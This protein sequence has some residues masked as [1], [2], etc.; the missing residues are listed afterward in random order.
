M[1][2]RTNPKFLNKTHGSPTV[3][4]LDAMLSMRGGC[5]GCGTRI[6]RYGNIECPVRSCLLNA[7]VCLSAAFQYAQRH[8]P[9]GLTTT[10]CIYYLQLDQVLAGI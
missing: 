10:G 6:C 1:G 8:H 2:S 7:V 5:E 9:G 4:A 3:S